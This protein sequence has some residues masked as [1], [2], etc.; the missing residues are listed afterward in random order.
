[1]KRQW[2][3]ML[4][5]GIILVVIG[6]LAA[7][8][9]LATGLAMGTLLAVVFL[10]G[11]VAS[12]AAA[13]RDAGWQA[14][15]VD[16]LFGVLALLGAIVCVANPFSGAISLAWLIGVLFLVSGIMEIL[17]ATRAS[18][19]R[20]LL[21]ILGVVDVV[22]GAYVTFAIDPA[23]GLVLLALMVGFGFI[24]RGVLLSALAIRIR[25]LTSAATT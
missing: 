5:T 6:V 22:L 19:D 10:I 2:G 15:V 7:L 25:N 12:L 23:G 24:A 21:G 1:M 8:H 14:K 18:S 20:I 3:W 17:A 13:F 9:P 4:A 16:I 11:G